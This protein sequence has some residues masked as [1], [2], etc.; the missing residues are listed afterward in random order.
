MSFEIKAQLDHLA[1]KIKRSN[2]SNVNCDFKLLL[3]SNARG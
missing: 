2:C 1:T 3:L